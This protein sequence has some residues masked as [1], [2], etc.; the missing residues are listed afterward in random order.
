[1]RPRHLEHAGIQKL[2]EAG[3]AV[4]RRTEPARRFILRRSFHQGPLT[5]IIADTITI[6][7]C[8]LMSDSKQR[9]FPHVHKR[10]FCLASWLIFGGM[11][12]TA[13]VGQMYSSLIF[14][15]QL[16]FP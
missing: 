11:E 5:G 1:M 4:P 13:A 15:W 6:P 8:L 7:L 2:N 9:P 12:P 3:S 16:H 14:S 10:F